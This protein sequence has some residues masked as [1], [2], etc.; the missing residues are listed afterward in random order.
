[1]TRAILDVRYDETLLSANFMAD[2]IFE[3]EGVESV[4]VKEES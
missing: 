4:T 3:L 2:H 1:M